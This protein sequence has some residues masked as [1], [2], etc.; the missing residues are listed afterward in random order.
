M[1]INA[2]FFNSVAGDRTYSA[3]DFARAFDVILQNGVIPED[4]GTLG[5]SVT[6][7]QFNVLNKGKAIIQGH[8]VD[9][10]VAETITNIPNWDFFGMIVLR[11]DMTNNRNCTV[12]VLSH[13]N[14][15]QDE[16]IWE[17]PLY[18]VSVAGGVI[19]SAQDLRVGG[20]AISQQSG[21]LKSSS[22]I[23]V[24]FKKPGFVSW[25]IQRLSDN[26]LHLIPSI[27][28]N[29]E[30]WDTSKKIFFSNTGNFEF[31]GNGVVKGSFTANGNTTL[32]GQLTMT[33]STAGSEFKMNNT[34]D[35]HQL[36]Q[37]TT[38]DGNY[39]DSVN[40]GYGIFRKLY[41]RAL[42]FITNAP[43]ITSGPETGYC[44]VGAKVLNNTTSNI[45]GVGVSFKQQRTTIPTSVTL[46]GSS[47]NLTTVP[48][49]TATHMTEQGFWLAIS[50]SNAGNDAYFYWRGHYS[51]T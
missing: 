23:P 30:D 2:Y 43:F 22:N 26:S 12:V 40:S 4:D 7:T 46:V 6:G 51:V 11:L 35:D 14:P 47:T 45:A 24:I 17:L 28:A 31:P 19:T 27:S 1:A 36:A 34:V 29:G 37:R 16:N 50:G 18:N 13:R 32:N 10:P 8:F 38:N 48:G 21:I 9:V 49:V 3:R 33:K 25:S 20:G 44:G 5:L 42:Q 39:I 15:Q 41:M